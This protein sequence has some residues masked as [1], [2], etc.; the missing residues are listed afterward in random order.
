ML[1]LCGEGMV[2]GDDRPMVGQ[3]FPLRATGVDHRLNR[4]RH[5]GFELCAVPGGADVRDAERLVQ[6]APNAVAAPLAND[7]EPLTLGIALNGRA[8]IADTIAN[9]RSLN[10]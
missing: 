1:K 5:P 10:T 4:E 7:A 9:L 3:Q 8:N 6:D 2:G